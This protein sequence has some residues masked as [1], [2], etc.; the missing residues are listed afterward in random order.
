MIK[1]DIFLS[2]DAL[3]SI[4]N[5]P[6]GVIELNSD[7]DLEEV[8]EIFIRMNSKGTQ[9]NQSDFAMS[10]FAVNDKYGEI[11]FVRL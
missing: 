1:D 3:R 2:L 8:T 4:V 5:V 10:K 9:L 7:L 11:S 6:V